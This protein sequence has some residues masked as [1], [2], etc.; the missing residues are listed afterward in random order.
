MRGFILFIAILIPSYGVMSQPPASSPSLPAWLAGCWSADNQE[1]G[2]GE[3]WMRPAGGMMLG[4]SQTVK[5]QKTVSYEYMR[6]VA[7]DSGQLT[8]VAMPLNQEETVFTLRTFTH[9]QLV[10]ENPGHDFP[11]RI[12]YEAVG[13]NKLHARIVGTRNASERSVDFYFTRQ[14]CPSL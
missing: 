11:Q 2:S 7:E 3:H 6:I 1:A 12:L 13:D 4:M 9:N 14:A 8:F 10:F 5:N